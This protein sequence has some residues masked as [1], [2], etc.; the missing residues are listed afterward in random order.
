MTATRRAIAAF[1]KFWW[2]FLVG[3][4][5]EVLVATIVVVGVALALRHHR[6]AGF[7]VVPLIA[8]VALALSALRGRGPS[9][10]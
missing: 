9:R 8:A 1:G 2:E 6:T 10:S 7:I 5:P 4:T 3:D